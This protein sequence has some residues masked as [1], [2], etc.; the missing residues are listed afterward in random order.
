MEISRK[1]LKDLYYDSK[2]NC[3]NKLYINELLYNNYNQLGGDC[4]I[5]KDYNTNERT[6]FLYSLLKDNISIANTLT[7]RYTIIGNKKT[8]YYIHSYVPSPSLIEADSMGINLNAFD[9]NIYEKCCNCI[10]FVVYAMF[11]DVDKIINKD[12]IR[13]YKMVLSFITCIK[14]SVENVKEYLKDW[15]VRI[16]L[17]KSIFEII[18][19][20]LNNECRE[21]YDICNKIINFLEYIFKF[22][23][24]EI[25]LV[26]CS[27]K[28]TK[29]DYAFSRSMR[30]LPLYEKDVNILICK[31]ADGIITNDE[32]K[33]IYNFANNIN[34][35]IYISTP[36][37]YNYASNIQHMYDFSNIND[38]NKTEDGIFPFYS[39]NCNLFMNYTVVGRYYVDHEKDFYHNKYSCFISFL[40]GCSGFKLKIKENIFNTKKEE[41]FII[42]KDIYK[43]DTDNFIN[44]DE[45][46]LKHLFRDYLSI[47]V[48]N[49]NEDDFIKKTNNITNGFI[50]ISHI[51]RN[52]SVPSLD[53]LHDLLIK[54]Y[55]RISLPPFDSEFYKYINLYNTSDTI[56]S[57]EDLTKLTSL[58]LCDILN[59]NQTEN[60]PYNY[61]VS[62][63][64][65]TNFSLS[66]LL[67]LN[68]N[69][70]LFNLIPIINYIYTYFK[71]AIVWYDD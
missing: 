50:D 57:K 55:R 34:K 33:N 51:R 69:N 38:I 61:I 25:Y 62:I 40:A 14:L 60:I 3:Y 17:N 5:T 18:N 67:N 13:K 43:N 28:C 35:I 42:V 44:Y 19:L 22:D 45:I 48:T 66:H 63:T 26:S 52:I 24:V 27:D 23:N 49:I 36:Y 70:F 29:I 58:I 31:D 10:T 65:V 47:D 71:S 21:L 2:S 41:A 64:G 59:Y 54:K 7:D 56:Y 11:E 4:S 6:T 8:N 30:F 16:Y 39:P 12:L 15:I 1:N 37:N 68:V 20:A 53:I 46:F 32:C 9:L